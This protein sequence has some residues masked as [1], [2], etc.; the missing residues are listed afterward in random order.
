M[1]R[2]Y[3]IDLET[4][5]K[6]RSL[7]PDELAIILNAR[8]G[9]TEYSLRVMDLQQQIRNWFEA[10]GQIVTVA[11]QRGYLRVLTDAEAVDYNAKA[12]SRGI[13]KLADAHKR[14]QGID[15]SELSEEQRARHEREAYVQG[16][17]LQA[18][19]RERKALLPEAAKRATPRIGVTG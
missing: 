9:T 17:L 10:S 15:V 12:F 5:A 3:N 16:R 1:S 14:T 2:R 6:G 4:M 18:M 7:S 11:L 19:T 8:E 13:R